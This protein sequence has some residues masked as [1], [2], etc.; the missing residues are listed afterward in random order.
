MPFKFELPEDQTGEP[1]ERYRR[2]KKIGW[3]QT[4]SSKKDE[5]LH[6]SERNDEDKKQRPNRISISKNRMENM[7]LLRRKPKI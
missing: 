7:T 2:K 6:R 5:R 1:E 4:L 3:R